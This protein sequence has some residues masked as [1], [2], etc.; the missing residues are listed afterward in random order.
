MRWSRLINRFKNVIGKEN[1]AT[2]ATIEKHGVVDIFFTFQPKTTK[3]IPLKQIRALITQ[4]PWTALGELPK[5]NI[6]D[7]GEVEVSFLALNEKQRNL[8]KEQIE[9]LFL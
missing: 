1:T 3:S 6:N 7:K 9:G 5:V 2:E 8:M 4:S